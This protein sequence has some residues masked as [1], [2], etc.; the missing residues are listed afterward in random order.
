MAGKL[1]RY[2]NDKVFAG[3]C[4]GIARYFGWQPRTVRLGWIVFT[5]LGGAGLAFYVL[6]W[7]IMPS[8]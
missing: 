1:V 4:S 7:I 5:L 2:S 3:V 6:F 8:D